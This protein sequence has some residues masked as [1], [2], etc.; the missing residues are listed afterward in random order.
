MRGGCFS[1]C[2][3]CDA[4]PSSPVPAFHHQAE[5]GWR[6][7]SWSPLALCYQLEWLSDELQSGLPR[8]KP[9]QSSAGELSA[10]SGL[11]MPDNKQTQ[12]FSWVT[13]G[14]RRKGHGPWR[15]IL[16]AGGGSC[17]QRWWLRRVRACVFWISLWCELQYSGMDRVLNHC[18]CCF[19][20]GGTNKIT[21]ENKCKK[22]VYCKCTQESVFKLD[23]FNWKKSRNYKW[24]CT[25][26]GLLF[27]L[28]PTDWTGSFRHARP[29]WAL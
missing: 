2:C 25:N 28:L 26:N 27:S 4:V 24:R 12:Q 3:V 19:F 22:A 29:P 21:G 20:C 1:R 13:H 18:T 9:E 23:S 17:K 11:L 15:K 6:L 14:W 10:W 7:L 8:A 5:A 16:E